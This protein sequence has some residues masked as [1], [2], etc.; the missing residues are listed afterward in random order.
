MVRANGR[1]GIAILGTSSGNSVE[2]N[3]ASGNGL[4]NLAPSLQFDLFAAVPGANL[5]R[6]NQ[7]TSNVGQTALTAADLAAAFG[8]GGCM[9][10]YGSGAL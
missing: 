6:N 4:L 5:W 9:S 1:A 2:N 3:D 10:P 7:G 8:P